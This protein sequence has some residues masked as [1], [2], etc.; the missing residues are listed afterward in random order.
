MEKIKATLYVEPNTLEKI[1]KLYRGDNC[2]SKSDFI[3]KAINFYAGYIEADNCKDYLPDVILSTVGAKLDVFGNRMSS[4][5][6]KLAVE[7][8]MLLHV[9]AATCDIDDITLSRLRG[10]CVEE[11]KRVHGNISLDQAYKYQRTDD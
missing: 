7:L 5:I 8:D 3:E 6:F 11:V 4:L 1:E 2:R 10:M 9:T